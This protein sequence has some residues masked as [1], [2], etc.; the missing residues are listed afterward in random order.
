MKTIFKILFLLQC[1][2][3][4]F[5]FAQLEFSNWV[6]GENT[7]LHINLDGTTSLETYDNIYGVYN[8]TYFDQILSDN[9]GNPFIKLGYT[10]KYNDFS[11]YMIY[12]FAMNYING[13]NCLPTTKNIHTVKPF[14]LK[15]P[16]N[17]YVYIIHSDCL[18]EYKKDYIM[19]KTQIYCFCKNN[20]DATDKGKDFLIHELQGIYKESACQLLP[21]ICGFSHTDGKSIWILTRNMD[22]DS[23][24]SIKLTGTEIIE[25]KNQNLI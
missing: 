6:V 23:I 24:T 15:S 7:I 14:M 13:T 8:K 16:D 17:K 25:K 20:F 21:F 3:P 5:S 2:Y 1:L 10:K 9:N 11:Y 19:Y 18:Y 22:T 4:S 12:K